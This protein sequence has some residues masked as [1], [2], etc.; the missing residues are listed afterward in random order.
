MP[1]QVK[2]LV[3]HLSLPDGNSYPA[4]NTTVTLTEEQY[5][6]LT[7]SHFVSNLQD[8][9]FVSPTVGTTYEA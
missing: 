6:Q 8:L 4:A 7:P 9:G 5:L 3:A 1:Y 2:T